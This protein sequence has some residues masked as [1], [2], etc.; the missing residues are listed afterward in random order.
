MAR[1][2]SNKELYIAGS[3]SATPKSNDLHPGISFLPTFELLAQIYA[4]RLLFQDFDMA[5]PSCDDFPNHLPAHLPAGVRAHG[6]VC[7][8]TR[9][10]C[11]FNHPG[12]GPLGFLVC[13][14]C[15]RHTQDMLRFVNV[16]GLHAAHPRNYELLADLIQFGPAAP[17]PNFQ[18]GH[19]PKLP[20]PPGLPA[21]TAQGL[22]PANVRSWQQVNEY[23]NGV[24]LAA[25]HTNPPF[26]EFLTRVCNRCEEL[27]ANE[28]H[29][30]NSFQIPT[31][32]EE[33][34]TWLQA[35]YSACTCWTTLGLQRIPNIHNG[36]PQR[37]EIMCK[38]HRAQV[39]ARLQAQK[40]R[41][42]KWLRNIA[43]VDGKLKQANKW[44]LKRRVNRP[45]YWRACRVSPAAM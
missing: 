23:Q 20:V 17:R 27:I 30:R 13:D 1:G 10:P 29:F 33:S 6:G 18:I 37:H 25:N 26:P 3:G 15:S 2:S 14:T 16:P 8:A 43:I 12:A 34:A 4:G 11:V 32:A 35:P 9:S 42:D 41:N 31:T 21:S 22:I 45:G 40:A 19:S 39:W 36:I 24:L 38:D 5:V 44:T 28:I 7:Q